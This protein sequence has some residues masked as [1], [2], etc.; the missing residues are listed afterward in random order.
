[1][2]VVSRVTF[3]LEGPEFIGAVPILKVTE[4]LREFHSTVDKAY[5]SIV[6]RGKVTRVDRTVYRLTATSIGIGSFFSNIEVIVP[7]A[8]FAL[9]VIPAGIQ[10]AHVWEVAKHA[11][12]FLKAMATLRREG[13]EPKV[14]V[15]TSGDTSKLLII[16]DNNNIEINHI[17]QTAATRGERHVKALARLVDGEHVSGLSAL[18]DKEE[19]ISLTPPDNDLFN[20]LTYMED[21]PAELM[22]KIFRLDVQSRTGR[23][24]V[25]SDGEELERQFRVIGRQSLHPYI[26][27]LERPRSLLKV[28]R[29]IERH[30]TGVEVVHMY[31]VLEVIST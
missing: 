8:D 28:L 11:F 22:A 7:V 3:S 30:P 9:S 23:L 6:A 10:P 19:G 26:V 18:D 12:T 17:V 2:P 27:A 14:Q 5:L 13:K 20:P 31:H 21:S 15:N 4:A 25:L 29:E 24:R 16:G 1:M